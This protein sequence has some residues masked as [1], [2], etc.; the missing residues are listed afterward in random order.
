MK[1]P[2]CCLIPALL[3]CAA[4][5]WA[6]LNI[7]LVA[8]ELQD[9]MQSLESM[10]QTE[11]EGFLDEILVLVEETLDKP[12]FMAAFNGATMTS[13][14]LPGILGLVDGIAI[15]VGS[16]G[17]VWSASYSPET[18]ASL[19]AVDAT[20]DLEL[21]TFIQP[22]TL[23]VGVPLG[24]LLPGLYAGGYLGWMK[25][26]GAL[27]GIESFSAGAFSGLRLFGNPE[28]SA[29]LRWNGLEISIGGGYSVGTLSMNIAP[30][31]IYQTIPL[32]PDG[33]GP[34]LPLSTTISVDPDIQAG[35]RSSTLGGRL[36]IS[37]GIALFDVLDLSIGGGCGL[38]TGS[39][40]ISIDARGQEIR[41]EGYLS[42]LV[43]ENGTISID[44]TT[45]AVEATTVYPY[46]D[47]RLGFR[48]GAF[49]IAMPF[50]WNIPKGIGVAVLVEAYL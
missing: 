8:P 48:V 14:L 40:A 4:T 41:I 26:S 47:A 30:G 22:L 21:G 10:L 37:T 50:V 32:D 44:G 18:F 15:S 20:T 38:S 35:V 2:V 3:L 46:L 16:S 33:A 28:Q 19:S 39:S 17:A 12:L 42:N 7:T 43:E 29:M 24:R 27:L 5:A 45:A 6:D 36:G 34:L 25:A 49:T 31:S 1:T 11:A 9:G 13:S 23:Q